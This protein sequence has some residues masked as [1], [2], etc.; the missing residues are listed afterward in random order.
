MR[1]LL[2]LL[3]GTTA[4]LAEPPGLRVEVA[5]PAVTVFSHA[6]DACAADDIPDAP[7]RAVRLA[8]GAVLLFA[9]HF[10]NRLL[11]GP[12]LLRVRPDC[13]VVYRGGENDDPAAFDDRGWLV[14]PYTLDGR[15]IF[16]LVHDEFQGHRRP[17]LCP[18]GTYLDCWYNAITLAV[19]DDGGRTFRRPARALVAALPYRYEDVVGAHRG[20]F[21]PSNVVALDTGFYVFAFAT[22]ALAQR[23]GNCL[24]RTTAPDEAGSWRGWNGAA[25]AVRFVDPYVERD[26]PAAHVCAPVEVEHLR[27]P[28]TS[29]VRHAPSGLFI[30]TMMN[31]AAGVFVATSRDLLHWSD[32]ALVWAGHGE[33]GWRCGAAPPVAYPSL[34]DPQ[35]ASADFATVGATA[36][37]FLTIWRPDGC[38][39]GMDRDL[40]RLPVRIAP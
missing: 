7:A 35:S 38:R 37:L 3:A 4:A 21:N 27:W 29:V 12:D 36:Q 8:S 28:V 13:R 14:S 16:S 30:A 22:E 15:R 5:G 23:P 6:R 2:A 39:L 31:G 10:T 32:P 1:W 17:W 25:F 34:L 40:I 19:S 33:G 9:P 11:R 20:Y 18:T 24:L 26:D